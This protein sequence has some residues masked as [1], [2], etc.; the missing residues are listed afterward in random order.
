MLDRYLLPLLAAP[1]QAVA[2][3][4]VAAGLSADL[5]T[6]TGAVVGLAAAPLIALGFP[7]WA[8]L[9]FLGNRFLDGVDGHVARLRGA[10]PRG[11][12]L[13]IACDFLVYAAIPLGF[14]FADPA[15]NALPAAALL[16]GFIG[17][18]TTFLAYAATVGPGKVNP[19][20]PNKGLYYLGGLT[21]GSETIL[22]FALMC[23]WPAHFPVMAWA[24]AA[25]C[26]LTTATRLYVGAA[27][28]D[29][30]PTHPEKP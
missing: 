13:D 26:A 23:L 6:L 20:Y 30:T 11:A 14:A 19:A 12:F 17:T 15:H 21:E 1:H 4:C 3:G 22:C 8:L 16:A 10:T 29:G 25:A 2:R 9:L 5:V 24:F 18:A 28:L 7:G 27:S